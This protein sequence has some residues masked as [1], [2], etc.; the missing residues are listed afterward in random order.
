M[1]CVQLQGVC[2]AQDVFLSFGATSGP[3]PSVRQVI[4]INMIS[5]DIIN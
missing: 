1:G 5:Y 2:P 3:S 4:K